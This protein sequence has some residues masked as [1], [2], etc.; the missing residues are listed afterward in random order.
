MNKVWS[1]SHGWLDA[2]HR[3]GAAV[4]GLA[5]GTFGVLG[6]VDRLDMFS[7]TGRP[8]L[9]LSSNGLLS[10]IS[11]VVAAVLVA[12]ALRGGRTASTVWWSSARRS[13]RPGW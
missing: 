13:W 11:L 4:F 8:V 9:G 5:I 1:D 10:V 12:A 3:V 2:L 6:L 7:T